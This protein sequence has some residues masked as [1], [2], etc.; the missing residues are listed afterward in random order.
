M[1]LVLTILAG[2]EK[3]IDIKLSEANEVIVIEAAITNSRI[4]FSVRVTKTAPYFGT[5]SIQMVSGAKVSVRVEGGKPKYFTE[6]SPG[7][8]T[9]EKTIALANFWYILDVEYEGVVYSARSFLNETV[10]IVNITMSYF[11]GLGFFDSGY[12]LNCYV[13]DPIGK[14]NF[15]RLRYFVHGKLVDDKGQISLYSDKFFDGKIIGLGQNS[16]V[17]NEK[18]TLL[19]ELN[20]IDK[21]AY[22]YLSTLENITSS[23]LM[24]SASPANPIGNFSN[25]ALGY[26]TA[27][28]YEK[29]TIIVSE[30]IK[31]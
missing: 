11:D 2:C 6:S 23:D 26:F 9:L 24:Q 1:V 18:D 27:Y 28:S 15:Y 31:K 4:P 12:K 8:Y 7:H 21:A 22:D 3:T 19:L 10:P 25:G 14:V 13:K 29:K 16:V 20:C 5:K 30:F 17:F